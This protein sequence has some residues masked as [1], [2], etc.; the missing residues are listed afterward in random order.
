[1]W[2]VNVGQN[3]VFCF[4][5][6]KKAFIWAYSI[7]MREQYE[8]WIFTVNPTT[9]S[10]CIWSMS[11]L[12][13]Q[14]I[15]PSCFFYELFRYSAKYRPFFFA[16]SHQ[17]HVKTKVFSSLLI[18]H[19]LHLSDV[20]YYSDFHWP[21]QIRKTQPLRC[22]Y[23]WQR[24]ISLACQSFHHLLKEVFLCRVLS[25]FCGKVL[26][27]DRPCF[28]LALFGVYIFACCC[29]LFGLLLAVII[30]LIKKLMEFVWYRFSWRLQNL[31]TLD[32]G[33]ILVAIRRSR[34]DPFDGTTGMKPNIF[35]IFYESLKWEA[36]CVIDISQHEHCTRS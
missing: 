34:D 26:S 7:R 10:L 4:Q 33:I 13:Y 3:S 18:S 23:F 11:N 19:F 36:L 27:I 14:H 28:L 25:D 2:P 17:H 21:P 15:S 30:W 9:L 12:W 20:P 35:A 31:S 29:V 24:I 22:G 5:L 1:M 6:H 8:T 16:Y 32:Y